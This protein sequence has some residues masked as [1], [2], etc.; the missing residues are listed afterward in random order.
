VALSTEVLLECPARVVRVID[1]NTLD[2]EA[3]LGSRIPT[4]MRC[5]LDGV[6]APELDDADPE[7]RQVAEHAK[8]FVE[9]LVLGKE[10]IV[11]MPADC[12]DKH[13]RWL[14]VVH[15]RDAAGDWSNLNE[16]L[17][18]NGLAASTFSVTEEVVAGA[19]IP[20]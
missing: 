6:E 18:E 11:H 17:I 16:D 7:E 9:V 14:A 1:G 12:P 2:L 10:V 13:G 5:R 19:S 3:D 4:L 8:D 15:W 20:N